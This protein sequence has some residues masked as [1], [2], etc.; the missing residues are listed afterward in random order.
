MQRSLSR[1]VGTGFIL[2]C[3][4]AGA[5]FLSRSQFGA[6]DVGAPMRGYEAQTGSRY[7]PL[8]SNPFQAP[9]VRRLDTPSFAGATSVWGAIGRDDGGDI[10][11]G[12]SAENAG[13]SAHLMRYDPVAQSWQDRGSVVDQLRK[14]G[15]HHDGEGQVKIHSKIIPADD[16]WLY[17]ASMDED[18]ENAATKAPPRWG[19]HL[20]RVDPRSNRWEH[21]IAAPEALIA[22]SGVGRYIYALGYWNHVLYQYDTTTAKS[23]RVVVGSVG[24]HVS[25]NFVADV[26]GHAYVPRLAAQADGKVTAALV[27]YDADLHEVGAT[28][29][30][31]YTGRESPDSNEGIVG[32]AY[33]SDGRI[34]FTTHRGQLYLIDPIRSGPAQVTPVGWLHPKGEAYAPSLFSFNGKSLLASVTQRDGAYEWVIFDLATGISGAFPLDTKTLR[35]VLLYGS[36]TRDNEGRFYVGGWAAEPAGGERPLVLQITASP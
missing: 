10:W 33:L 15:I 7:L 25:R 19:G 32:L 29:L 26:R 35:N 6:D 18:G 23:R 5:L 13:M 31:F 3:G 28:S 2:L 4:V 34:V 8:P 9:M 11:V 21:L 27:E 22:V 24:Q 30:E 36:I 14:E 17:F 16:G 12:V 20:W 1:L